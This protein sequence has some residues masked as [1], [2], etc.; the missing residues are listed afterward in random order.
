MEVV[1]H[2]TIMQEPEAKAVAIAR[3]QIKEC[4]TILV[5]GENRFP[6]V[7][8]VH[9][10]KAGFLGPLQRTRHTGHDRLWSLNVTAIPR[11]APNLGTASGAI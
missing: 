6:I 11:R 8:P 5:I 1:G 10:V 9:Q 7:A 4:A 3:H 2:Q